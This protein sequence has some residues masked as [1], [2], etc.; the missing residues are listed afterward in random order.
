MN[1]RFASISIC[2]AVSLVT[3]CFVRGQQA[4]PPPQSP[5]PAVPATSAKP[6]QSADHAHDWWHQ[7]YFTKPLNSPDGKKL[8]LISV[9]GNRF[10]DAEGKAVLFRGVNIA[11]PD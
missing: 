3:A 2:L 9:R 11:D 8:P 5:A 10:V 6:Q 4:T 1:R 7:A